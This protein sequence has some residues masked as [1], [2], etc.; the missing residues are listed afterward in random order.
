MIKMIIKTYPVNSVPCGR[1]WVQWVQ[2]WWEWCYSE[3]FEKSPV[4]DVLGDF[5]GRNQIFED[6][7]FLAGTF[8][9][10]AERRCNI[11][12]GRSIFFPLVNDLI[13]FASD[14]HLKTEDELCAYAKADLDETKFPP[15][16]VAVDG[17]E[18][19][20]LKQYRIQTR[21][22]QLALPPKEPDGIPVMTKATSD[23]YWVFLEPLPI[24]EHRIEFI[25]EKL[26]YDRL[27]VATEQSIEAPRFTVEVKYRIIV[28]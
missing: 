3:P 8:G 10:K 23:G 17:F 13:A 12:R 26:D 1:S 16:H 2:S 6:V 11:P 7:W 19:Q 18:I 4:S 24:G 28:Y 21:V 20:N 27:R 9:G 15:T 14:P 5:C 25:G 22:F